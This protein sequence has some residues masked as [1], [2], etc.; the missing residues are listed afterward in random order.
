[1]VILPTLK[2][3]EDAAVVAR[4]IVKLLDSPSAFTGSHLLHVSAS[5]GIGIYPG[6]ARSAADLIK[7]ADAA[8]YHAKEGGRNRYQFFAP[9]MNARAN[10]TLA[11]ESGLRLALERDEFEIY[12]QP[13]VA[14][15]EGNLIGMEALLRWRHPERGLITPESFIRVA[16]ERG[17]I[18][19]IGEWVL[20]TAC[21]QIRAWQEEG[22]APIP[23]SVNVSPLQFR[24]KDLPD[25]IRAALHESGLDS[26]YLELE[27]TEG[28]LMHDSGI[29]NDNIRTLESMGLALSIDDF[30]TGYS[31]LSYLKRLPIAKV[32]VDRSFVGDIPG[33][34]DDAA[35]VSAII[36]TAFSL[37]LDVIA[38]GVETAAQVAFLLAAGCDKAQGNYFSEPVPAGAFRNLMSARGSVAPEVDLLGE[39]IRIATV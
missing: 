18:L 24:S 17:L 37:K 27:I 4:K 34:E 19:P 8:M 15:P 35:I 26:R 7:C 30:G 1:M 6:D 12:Y 14:L 22:F 39:P 21:R 25:I 13:Q 38:E 31:S 28:A 3:S 20:H 16:E 29:T 33:D 5:V 11:L 36:A 10:E 2:E 9:E 32:K 23:V